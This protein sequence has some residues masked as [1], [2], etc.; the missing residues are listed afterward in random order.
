MYNKYMYCNK[1]VRQKI[2]TN[3][4]K[5]ERKKSKLPIFFATLQLIFHFSVCIIKIEENRIS[6]RIYKF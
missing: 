2:K 6:F 3:A 1:Y 5:N 4:K